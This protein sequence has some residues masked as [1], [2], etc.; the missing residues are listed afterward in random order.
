MASL[1]PALATPGAPDDPLYAW[2]QD[3]V[4]LLLRVFLL[5]GIPLL[6]LDA[7]NQFLLERWALVI[8]D[9]GL[10][11]LVIALALLPRLNHWLRSSVIISMFIIRSM[12]GLYVL[13]LYGINPAV[14]I[15]GIAV[16][17]MLLGPRAALITC[18]LSAAGISVIFG[19]FGLGLFAYPYEPLL[20][21][22][23]A[24]VLI[25]QGLL[26][27]GL[28]VILAIMVGSLVNALQTSL[29][30]NQATLAELARLKAALDAHL[31]HHTAEAHKTSVLLAASQRLAHVG[32]FAHRPHS[33][34]ITWTD[35]LYRIHEVPPGTVIDWK[36]SRQLYPEALPQIKQAFT[37]LI[38]AH[39]PYELEIPARTLTGRP[40]W[41]RVSGAADTST[42]TLHFI[43][44]VQDITAR[45]QSEQALATQLRYAEALAQCSRTLLF[46]RAE[47]PAW[48][49]V[50]QQVL[51]IL[52]ATVDCSRLGLRIL[53]ANTAEQIT[54]DIL[55]SEHSSDVTP[56]DHLPLDLSN[57]PPTLWQVLADGGLLIGSPGEIFPPGNPIHSY[58]TRNQVAMLLACG[59]KIN[60]HWRGYLLATDQYARSWDEASIRML[61]T[62]LEMISAFIQQWETA[63]ALRAREAQLRALGD[64]LPNGFIYQYRYDQDQHSTFTFLSEGIQ[65]VLG[66]HPNDVLA[67]A[68]ILH[69]LIA[70]EER[71]RHAAAE[72]RSLN[73]MSVFAE[74]FRHI[75]DDGSERWLYLCSRPRRIEGRVVIWDGVALDISERQ[76]VADELARA[77]DAAEA[78]TRAKSTFLATMSHE[79]RTPLNAVI[80]MANLLQDTPLSAEQRSFA[81]TISTG[82]QAL[83]ALINDI[84]DASRIEAGRIELEL[85][86]FD[87][88]ACIHSTI[89]LISYD[90][91]QKGLTITANCAP[92]LPH[93]VIGDEARLRQILLNLLG[94]AVK[95]T[96]QGEVALH[97]TATTRQDQTALVQL[98]V[99]DTGIGISA[100]Q[101]AHIFEPFVQ[102]DSSTA[103]RYGGS[104]LG[105]AISRQLVSLMGGNLEVESSPGDGATFSLSLPL[106]LAPR[107]DPPPLAALEQ[108]ALPRLNILVAEDNM[109]NQELI[110]RMLDRMGHQ[111]SVADNGLAAV[112]AV[113]Q[114][115]YDVVLMD[116]QMPELDG[117]AATR[118]IRALGPAVAQP[119][120]ITLTANA[121]ASDRAHALQAGMD[122]FLSKPVHPDDLRRV[123]AQVVVRRP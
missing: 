39:E 15:T 38:A 27:L 109:V 101:Q 70:P 106:P 1:S 100:E 116:M 23:R 56:F 19:G 81:A 9:L 75:L 80:G 47:T 83:L 18:L 54:A 91:R 30:A 53:P 112:A 41:V 118:Q 3:T 119:Y 105:L 66:L 123:L 35:E 95:F 26:I 43:G 22:T 31:K 98:S 113:R 7:L 97:A 14:L 121:L 33:P 57:V 10:I 46:T 49:P 82:G 79:I 24:H 44:A 111:V 120:I 40:L 60:E 107:P 55:L 32:G 11:A 62:S 72:Q 110:R 63:S 84:L 68:R 74:V 28:A 90:A 59:I 88:P 64:N 102:A 65:Q 13:G 34:T 69:R 61:R 29:Q 71:E 76:R 50:I 117:E 6:M 114:A 103:R 67:D 108:A 17:V 2:R 86:P 58:Y 122:A 42:E 48:E 20:H 93:A 4:A 12:V 36:L 51:A 52:R 115:S 77:R 89:T 96:S 92:S 8:W 45:K 104:G 37:R 25:H 21:A 99:R 87:L 16:S 73:E 85:R 78:A 5:L 94:N